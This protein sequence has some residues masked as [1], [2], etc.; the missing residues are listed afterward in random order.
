VT[1]VVE[2]GEKARLFAVAL[3]NPNCI[4]AD[5]LNGSREMNRRQAHLTKAIEFKR[6]NC[7]ADSKATRD[8]ESQST[9]I[10]ESL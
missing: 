2:A 1:L 7:K 3:W 9:L 6:D 5:H 4:C 10:D 8:T